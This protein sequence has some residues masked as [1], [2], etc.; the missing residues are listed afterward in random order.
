M[1]DSE[2]DIV[3]I[4]R[5]EERKKPDRT[6]QGRS[7]TLSRSSM[8]KKVLS[9]VDMSKH[10]ASKKKK[11]NSPKT[12]RETAA[13]LLPSSPPS[14]SATPASSLVESLLKGMEGQLGSKIEQIRARVNSNTG[15]I[16][17]H[18]GKMAKREEI[19]KKARASAC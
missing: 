3:V 13:R 16:D 18:A 11:T 2:N 8:K 4:T 10:I 15:A 5:K 14:S 17:K 1:S 6:D 12:R 7:P 9:Y 19:S